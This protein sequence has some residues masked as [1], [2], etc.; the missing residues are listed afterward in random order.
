MTPSEAVKETMPVITLAY[1]Q[2][3]EASFNKLEES[4]AKIARRCKRLG[5]PEVTVKVTGL[6]AGTVGEVP[7]NILEIEL[8]GVA[9]IIT[10]WSFVAA[11][12][13]DHEGQGNIIRYTPPFSEKDVDAKYRT[14]SPACD[15]C[16]LARKRNDTYVVRNT[17]TQEE[18]QVGRTCLGDFFGGTN[19]HNIAEYVQLLGNVGIIMDEA[20]NLGWSGSLAHKPSFYPLLPLL[21][22]AAAVIRVN[23]KFVSGKAAY[24]NG[25]P[26]TADVV[27]SHMWNPAGP[28]AEVAKLYAPTLADEETAKA[29]IAWAAEVDTTGSDY[30]W[31][32]ATI[33]NAEMATVKEIGLAVSIVG[34][35]LRNLADKP[36]AAS[37]Y[38]GKVNDQITLTVRLDKIIPLQTSDLYKFTDTN[39][40]SISWFCKGKGLGVIEGATTTITGTVMKH[41]EFRG[42]KQTLLYR[43]SIVKPGMVRAKAGSASSGSGDDKQFQNV[44]VPF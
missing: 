6:K 43:V 40:N 27:R 34:V 25:I 16:K 17:K 36:R 8:N 7:C 13:H 3:P 20:K 28:L 4:I 32:I 39:G 9:P 37:Q 44:P 38:V 10:D 12:N 18:K 31:N 35:Y 21:A 22:R 14:V 30:L 42:V 11:L 1:Y 33:A 23:G 24:E 29:A 5:Y 2:I 19:P 41:E 26:S 15:H